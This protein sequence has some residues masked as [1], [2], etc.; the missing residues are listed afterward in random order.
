VV[1]REAVGSIGCSQ[2]GRSLTGQIALIVAFFTPHG[3]YQAGRSLLI[4]TLMTGPIWRLARSWRSAAGA[5]L[6]LVRGDQIRSCERILQALHEL[7]QDQR[8]IETC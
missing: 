5:H 8:F 6:S 7:T 2:L 4:L 3:R 1:S